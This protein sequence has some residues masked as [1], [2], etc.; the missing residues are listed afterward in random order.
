VFL[1]AAERNLL[2]IHWSADSLI[3]LAEHYITIRGTRYGIDP[4]AAGDQIERKIASMMAAFPQALVSALG[5]LDGLNLR[6]PDDR[7]VLAAAIQSQA[8]CIVT[9]NLRDFPLAVLAEHGVELNSPDTFLLGLLDDWPDEMLQV[10]SYVSDKTRRP[11][12]DLDELLT[13]LTRSAPSFVA[14]VAAILQTGSGDNR[15]QE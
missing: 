3:E 1:T 6:D 14:R 5:E 15:H 4:A 11:H 12:L 10:L 13:R 7:H 2:A 8:D 9:H